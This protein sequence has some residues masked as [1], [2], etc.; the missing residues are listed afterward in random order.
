VV[1]PLLTSASG[2]KFGKSE[3]GNVWLDDQ[4]TSPFRFYQYWINVDD[5]D[6]IRFVR[7]FTLMPHDEIAAL[8]HAVAAEP[9][10]RAAQRALATDITRRLHGETGLAAAERATRALFGGD[11]DGLGADDIA[12]VFADVPSSEIGADALAGEGVPLVDLLADSGL[13]SSKGDA[14]RAI[15]GGGVYVNGVRAADVSRPVRMEDAIDGRF[16]LLRKG[17]KSYHLVAVRR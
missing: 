5:A 14:R 10:Q 11:L 4:L 15:E 9:Q 8:E 17:K 7:L 16:V 12:D 6:A 13:A 1:F 3:A 2:A